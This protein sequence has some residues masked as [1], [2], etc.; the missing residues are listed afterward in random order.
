MLVVLQLCA[1]DRSDAADAHAFEAKTVC[2]MELLMLSVLWW[3][4]HH[5]TSFS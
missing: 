4:K 1:A 3:R 5:I 2:E